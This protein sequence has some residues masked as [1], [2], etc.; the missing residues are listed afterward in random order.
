MPCMR[1]H[2]Q[3]VF[4]RPVL[5][6]GAD[7]GLQQLPREQLPFNLSCNVPGRLR[8]VTTNIARF[9]P[10]VDWPPDLACTFAWNRG[11]RAYDGATLQLGADVPPST[12]LQTQPLRMAVD[13]VDSAAAVAATGGQWSAFIGG[14]GDQLPEVPPDGACACSLLTHWQLDPPKH[15]RTYTHTQ[16]Q[17]NTFEPVQ[18]QQ[19]PSWHLGQQSCRHAH[20]PCITPTWPACLPAMLHP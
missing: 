5:A 13:R 8:W 16:T 17:H 9:D 12:R 14:P 6:L 20:P 18:K 2:P 19:R 10:S 3:A 15:T 11:L 1:V 4:S 7:W